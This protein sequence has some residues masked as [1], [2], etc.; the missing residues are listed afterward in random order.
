MTTDRAM[1]RGHGGELT[2]SIVSSAGKCGS[3]L[4]DSSMATLTEDYKTDL[5]LKKQIFLLNAENRKLF[6]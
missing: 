3:V 4:C 2:G 1:S 6:S 5:L